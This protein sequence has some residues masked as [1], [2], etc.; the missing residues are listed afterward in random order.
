MELKTFLSS[1]ESHHFHT[2]PVFRN[3]FDGVRTRFSEEQPSGLI[4]RINFQY[5][6]DKASV[7]S[8]DRA[9]RW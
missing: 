5:L 2:R 7:F 4:L 8:N 6:I 1:L 9:M 3:T